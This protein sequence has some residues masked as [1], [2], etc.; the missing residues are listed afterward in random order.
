MLM[1]VLEVADGVA[2]LEVLQPYYG[3]DVA[4]RH[5]GNARLPHAR[6]G[7][8]FLNLGLLHRAVAVGN[9]DVH[10]LADGAPVNAA[11]GDAAGV[12][13]VVERGDEHLRCALQLLRCGYVLQYLVEQVLDVAGGVR[14]VGAHPAV[15][16][17][18]V[19]DGEVQLVL[20]AA[21]VEHQV[22][23][24]LIHLLGTAVQFVHLVHDHD[25]LQSD[26]QG[27]AQHEAGLRHGALEG[28]DQKQATVGHVQHALHLAAEVGVTRS[29]DDIN[30]RALVVNTYILGQN[31]NTAFA[32]QLIVIQHQLTCLLVI[33][34]QVPL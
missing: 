6:E 14:V 29:V 26:F 1:G 21:K 23:D 32:L 25:G 10:A 13:R 4:A 19:D 8:E 5:L 33:A 31:G 11:H 7:V 24:H 3:T 2:N 20:G 30:L 9:G 15:L 27:L 18:T 12:N 34:K 28:I 17:R 22:E 16:G